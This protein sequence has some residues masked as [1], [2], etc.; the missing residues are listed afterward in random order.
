[1]LVFCG[2][3]ALSPFRLAERLH[4]LRQHLPSIYE[5]Q[6][7]YHYFIYVQTVLSVDE[8][9]QLAGLLGTAVQHS[10]VEQIT[11]TQQLIVIPRIG[12]LSPWASKATDIAH[13]CGLHGIQ[14]IERGIIFTLHSPTTLPP[15]D[16]QK[17]APILHDR[18]TQS[19]VYSI[20]QVR[21]LFQ[22]SSAQPL[23]VINLVDNGLQAL[24]QA[25]ERLGLALS[26]GEM[27]YL[28]TCY[29]HLQRNATDAE[30]MMFAQA[31]SEHCRHKIFNARWRIDGQE[32]SLSLFQMIKHSY[33]RSPQNVLSAYQDNAA[34]LQG[35][36]VER[37]YA[38]T[39]TQHYHWHR[40]AN[41]ILLKVET[42]N[43]PTAIAPY[44]GAATG[45]GGEIRDEG[46]TGLGGKPKAGLTG[47]SVSNLNIPGFR[48]PWEIDSGRPDHIVSALEIMLQG[49]LGSAA[50]NN[51]F[52]RPNLLGYFRTLELQLIDEADWVRGY[53]K[54]IMLAGGL[55]NIKAEHVTKGELAPGSLLV[56]LG[57]P[58]MQIG[59]GGGAASSLATQEG[60]AE[61]DFASVQRDNA[62]MQRRCQEVIDRCWALGTDNPIA[63]IHDVGAGGLSNALPELVH[64][65]GLGATIE[66][67]AIDNAEPSMSPLALWC[68]EA[69]ERY[70][71]AIAPDDLA[72]FKALCQRERCP[73]AVVGQ[74]Q[75]SKQL[76]VTDSLLQT[77]AV[78][79]PLA[80]VLGNAPPMQI[81]VQRTP[82]LRPELQLNGLTLDDAISRVLRLPCVASKQFLITIGDP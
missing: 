5:L 73:M 38:D 14:R 64:D 78:D 2:A 76:T 72:R 12:T 61:L 39:P 79:L 36:N 59:L 35:P 6:A 70:V 77:P 67:R 42:H 29:Q 8:Q 45:A 7:Q 20:D 56:V 23:T 52:G 55:G 69:Q 26:P 48:Q 27:Q 28:L 82:V 13:N 58:A 19:L 15:A 44:A 9:Q 24:Q 1:M 32:Q 51:E 46:A 11:N 63:F 22:H 17:I 18:M 66:L 47:F 68:N 21:A 54:P 62:E 40:Q 30:L 16:C 3:A 80:V 81:D 53:H 31:N 37:F 65:G 49:P 57:G 34:V 10:S 43:H 41:P 25:N 60:Q 75:Q 74:A 71:L 4:Q 33:Q 50:F